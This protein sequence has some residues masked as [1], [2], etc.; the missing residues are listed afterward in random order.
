[1]FKKK[2]SQIW[3][4]TDMIFFF[5]FYI[6]ILTEIQYTAHKAYLYK[7]ASHWLFSKA[8]E[9]LPN[10][11]I[12]LQYH[13][14]TSLVMLDCSQWWKSSWRI[15]AVKWQAIVCPIENQ[16]G[17]WVYLLKTQWTFRRHLKMSLRQAHCLCN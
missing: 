15:V 11:T 14:F 17:H 6:W 3:Y 7:E 10:N 5:T 2:K 9:V 1:M 16:R 13:W 8:N 12:M 4:D